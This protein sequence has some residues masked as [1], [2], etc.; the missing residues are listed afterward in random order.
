MRAESGYRESLLHEP[1]SFNRRR[2]Y[3]N[4]GD[5]TQGGALESEGI[6]VHC[7]RAWRVIPLGST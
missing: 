5:L 1:D 7:P 2:N 6:I 4:E 3:W